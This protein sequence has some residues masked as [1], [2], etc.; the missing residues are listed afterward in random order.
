MNSETTNIARPAHLGWRLLALV[1]D[2]MP[3]IALWIA[4][5]AIALAIKP[6]H[7]PFAPWSLGQVSLWGVCWLVTGAY[8]VHS[9]RRSGQ[10]LGMRPWRLKVIAADGRPAGPRALAL[11][12]AVSTLSL[13]ALGL[14]FLWSLFER[15]RR[16]WHDL[17]SATVMVR[18]ER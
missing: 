18:T 17:A 12:Y 6:G 2:A 7:A 16:T 4:V 1:Y 15:E 10:T 9:W 13:A 3:N 8:A 11:R 14:G 5:S